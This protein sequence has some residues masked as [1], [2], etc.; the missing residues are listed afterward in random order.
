MGKAK[1]CCFYH[2]TL[3]DFLPPSS[4]ANALAAFTRVISARCPS[5]PN[6]REMATAVSIKRSSG[7][8][9]EIISFALII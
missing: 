3:A 4:A 6:E 5:T 1:T 7:F 2:I 8:I 9:S